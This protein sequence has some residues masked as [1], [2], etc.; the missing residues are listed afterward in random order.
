MCRG[1]VEY[2]CGLW[3]VLSQ[4]RHNHI[5]ELWKLHTIGRI[6]NHHHAVALC[7]AITYC[8]HKCNTT[9]T[10]IVQ[11]KRNPLVLVRP[12]LALPHVVVECCLI[13]VHD[14]GFL[15]YQLCKLHSIFLS[16]ELQLLC[17]AIL[18]HVSSL[19]SCVTHID[20]PVESK[21]LAFTD[22]YSKFS[23]NDLSTLS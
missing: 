14:R 23:L 22:C 15:S 17:S 8:S 3:L 19:W 1:V 11:W 2:K 9:V 18:C 21:Q 4:S 16:H 6:S 12:S 5:N 13:Q 10:L 20:S 7:K